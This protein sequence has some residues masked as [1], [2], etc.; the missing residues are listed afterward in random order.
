MAR[1]IASSIFNVSVAA[2]VSD[3]ALSP[4]VDLMV[5]VRHLPFGE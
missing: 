3:D 1:V 5:W 4:G 2:G